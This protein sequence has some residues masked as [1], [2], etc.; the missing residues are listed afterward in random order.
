MSRLTETLQGLI[1][2][3]LENI[4]TATIARVEVVNESTLDVVPVI[5][6]KVRGEKIDLPK[7]TEVPLIT[8]QG[9]DSYSIPPVVVGDYVILLIMERCFDKWW[10]G[11]DFKTPLEARVHDYTDAIALAGV[12]PLQQAITIPQV[13][14]EFG[15]RYQEG[16]WE[17]LGDRLITG[18]LTVDGNTEITG[19]LTVR[20]DVQVDGN[21]TVDG[22]I[23]AQGEVTGKGI[24]LST[25]THPGDSGGTTGPPN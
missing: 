12:N 18:D 16:N 15:D 24:A 7:F 20:G 13:W 3:A 11:Q 10:D 17:Q 23:T 22:D 25:H 8:L 1:K 9:G 4:H 14:T 2:D 19:N 5:S 21:V 6:R